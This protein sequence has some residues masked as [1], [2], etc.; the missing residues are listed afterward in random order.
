M[1]KI[2]QEFKF[3]LSLITFEPCFDH[4]LQEGEANLYLSLV[5][6]DC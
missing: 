5:S 4:I 6:Y 1:F 3:K 2:E